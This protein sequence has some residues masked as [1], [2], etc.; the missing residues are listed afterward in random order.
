MMNAAYRSF[1]RSS[2]IFHALRMVSQHL[3]HL[4]LSSCCFNFLLC[5]CGKGGGLYGK[6]LGQ[7][8]IAQDLH[9]VGGTW[10]ARR[11]PEEPAASTVAPSSNLFRCGH[12]DSGQGLCKDVVEAAL[13]QATCQRHLA[14]FEADADAAAAASLLALVA[15]ASGLAIAGAMRHG[16][17][18]SRTLVEPAAGDSSC[19]FIDCAPPYCSSVTWSR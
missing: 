15:T 19:S 16:P 8:A 4:G 2:G 6:L 13:G 14:A 10:T 9:A 18:A 12:I 5:G 11:N 3:D 7:L 17:C 1:F